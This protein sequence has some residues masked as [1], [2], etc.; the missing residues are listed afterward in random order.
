[1]CTSDIPY[2]QSSK[3]ELILR[4]YLAAQRTVLANERTLLAYTRTALT[5]LIG[6]VT[7][8]EFFGQVAAH[9]LGW[10]FLPAAGLTVVVGVLKYRRM[11]D[12]LVRIGGAAPASGESAATDRRRDS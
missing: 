6:G 8:I 10:V 5:L 11:K 1:M 2:A 4:D 3:E 12:S 9:A 7:F